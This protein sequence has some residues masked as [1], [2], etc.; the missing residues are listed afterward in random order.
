MHVEET[1]IPGA[2]VFTPQVHRDRRG[3]FLEWFREPEFEMAAGHRFE[4][5][6]ANCSVS[7]RGVV[8]GVHL[9]KVPPGQG[10]YITCVSGS[11]NDIVVDLRLGSATYGSWASVRLD[12]ASHRAVYIAPGLGHG[13]CAL[14]DHSVVVYMCDS[15]YDP[16]DEVCVQPLDPGLA[17]DWG[18]GEA[19][20]VLSAKDQGAPS[21]EEAER[22]GLLPSLFEAGKIKSPDPYRRRS[23]MVARVDPRPGEA[24]NQARC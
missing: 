19:P 2:W 18:L 9:T 15:V 23:S 3:T 22:L 21:L 11:V 4:L 16:A 10:K 6:Q 5:A 17:I 8:R 13:F 7:A 24:D 1:S 12:Q 14:E 20:P